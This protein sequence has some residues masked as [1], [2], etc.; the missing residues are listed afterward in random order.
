MLRTS[1]KYGEY[2]WTSI[3]HVTRVRAG[4]RTQAIRVRS[5]CFGCLATL[6]K[7][8]L[9]SKGSCLFE[10]TAGGS[11][12]RCGFC[13]IFERSK[14]VFRFFRVF[15]CRK[16]CDLPQGAAIEFSFF[17]IK[18]QREFWWVC[19]APIDQ[20]HVVGI[21]HVLKAHNFPEFLDYVI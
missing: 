13:C 3:P 10:G 15:G 16:R 14:R 11:W 9:E 6:Q 2:F 7:R 4:K 1:I 19:Q 17:P 12:V 5:S 8:H 21:Y 20:L 18:K